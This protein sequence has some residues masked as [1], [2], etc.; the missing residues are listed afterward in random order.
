[1]V[2]VNFMGE[3]YHFCRHLGLAIL[4]VGPVAGRMLDFSAGADLRDERIEPRPAY[5]PE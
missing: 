4:G 3:V 1:M 2:V 5:F